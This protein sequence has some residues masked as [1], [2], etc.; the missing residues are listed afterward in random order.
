MLIEIQNRRCLRCGH[1]FRHML[2]GVT[3]SMFLRCPRCSCYF[4]VSTGSLPFTE[5]NIHKFKD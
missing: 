1:K 3:L 4:T 2:G 5:D